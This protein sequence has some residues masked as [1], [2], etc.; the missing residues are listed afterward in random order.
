MCAVLNGHARAQ[1]VTPMAGHWA[2]RRDAQR[3]S[4]DIGAMEFPADA[5]S[6]GDGFSDSQEGANGT[7][8]DRYVLRLKAGRNLISLCRKPS[9]SS[10]YAI[11]GRGALLGPVW[12]WAGDHYEQAVTLEPLLGYWV[13]AAVDAEVD[14]LLP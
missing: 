9:D 8:W 5:D 10:P 4:I 11:F 7:E 1:R 13:H 12:Q 3:G 14:V 6:D 2:Y